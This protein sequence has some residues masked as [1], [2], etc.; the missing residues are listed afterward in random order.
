[1]YLVNRKQIDEKKDFVYRDGG[2]YLNDFGRKTYLKAFLQRMEELIQIDD[3]DIKA[4]RWDLLTKQ[5]RAYKRFVYEPCQGYQLEGATSAP[6]AR[7]QEGLTWQAPAPKT[8]LLDNETG[9]VSK[10][11][12]QAYP[13]YGKKERS[14]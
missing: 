13:V 3:S 9:R 4:P 8:K 7:Y 1:M 11:Y 5:V 14:Y 6:K 12:E 2:C 10:T